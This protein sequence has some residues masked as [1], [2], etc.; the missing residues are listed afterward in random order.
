MEK[1]PKK[2]GGGASIYLGARG[3]C[4]GSPGG[5]TYPISIDTVG[6]TASKVPKGSVRLKCAMCD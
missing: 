6:V 5:D 1:L 2:G 3:T 4:K